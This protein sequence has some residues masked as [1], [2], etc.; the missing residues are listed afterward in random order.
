MKMKNRF[1][2]KG[3]TMLLIAGTVLCTCSCGNSKKE[4]KEDVGKYASS[5]VMDKVAASM[6]DLPEMV[7]I[8]SGDK[9]ADKKFKVFC[10]IDYSKVEDYTYEYAKDNNN[11]PE[12]VVVIR[13]KSKNDMAIVK[14]GLEDRTKKRVEHFEQ[15]DAAQIPKVEAAAISV[16]DNYILYA[17]GDQASNAKFEF[18]DMLGK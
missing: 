10:D 3:L 8:K 11:N 4:K 17:V 12:E 1:L 18:N 13:M 16:K 9:N 7:T 5:E 15:Y 14:K 6:T 2:K